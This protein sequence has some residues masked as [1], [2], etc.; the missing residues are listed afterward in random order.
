MKKEDEVNIKVGLLTLFG[1]ILILL[2]VVWR[3]GI[4]LKVQG[5]ELVG[6]FDSVSGLLETAPVLYRGYKVGSVVQINPQAK[7]VE[8]ISKLLRDLKLPEDSYLRIEYNGLVGQKYLSIIPGIS[9]YILAK[10]AVLK[11]VSTAGM[12]EFI[13][14]GSGSMAE[15]RKLLINFNRSFAKDDPNTSFAKIIGNFE[16]IAES[17]NRSMPKLES[18]LTNLDVMMKELV[19]NKD[20]LNDSVVSTKIAAQNIA[21]ISI[22][23]NETISKNAENIDAIIYEVKRASKRLNK[24]LRTKD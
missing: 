9:K 6:R 16:E 4:L 17:L 1:I 13:N 7:K 5:N 11:G 10:G 14:E 23:L 12:A 2:L 18:S 15:A 20:N 21:S 3:S 24:V 22:Q 8:V 19:A